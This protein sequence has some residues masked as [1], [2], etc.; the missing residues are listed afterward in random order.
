MPLLLISNS[1]LSFGQSNATNSIAITSSN[2]TN[3][4]SADNPNNEII[5]S[6]DTGI[7]MIKTGDNDGAK[8]S[9]YQ[10]EASLE[11]QP[12]QSGAEKHIEASLK[13]LKDGD[14][15]GALTH[16]E[17]AKKGLA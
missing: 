9:L 11:D 15:N 3:T 12:N 16:A 10:S 7:L 2:Q 17:E 14:T 13:A 4:T 1:V 6:I 5:K 8:K